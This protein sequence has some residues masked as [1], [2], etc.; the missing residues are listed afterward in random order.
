MSIQYDDAVIDVRILPR[1]QR[2][3]LV[4]RRFE[5]LQPG[6]AMEIVNDH[7]PVG[8][9]YSFNERYPG[10]FRWDYIQSGPVDWHVRIGREAEA[11][12]RHDH[13][14]P[15]GCACGSPSGS[16]G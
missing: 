1:P 16:C 15:E 11:R 6:E 3:V 2:H 4:F 14:H 13:T 5:E 12:G 7:D 10:I 9:F 8:L